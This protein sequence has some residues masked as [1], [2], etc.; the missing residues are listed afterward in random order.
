M[1]DLKEGVQPPFGLIYNFSQDKLVILHEYIN[2]NLEKR[3]K[4]IPSFQLVP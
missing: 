2:E 4:Y 3:F 1:I